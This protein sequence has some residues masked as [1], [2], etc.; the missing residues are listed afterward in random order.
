MKKTVYDILIIS[1]RPPTHSAGLGNASI[2]AL[3]AAGHHVD[4]MT[5]FDYPD[6]ENNII[7][8]LPEISQIKPSKVR[9]YVILPIRKVLLY[10]NI[11]TLVKRIKDRI[12]KRCSNRINTK[13]LMFLYPDES[14]PPIPPAIIV[15]NI[16]KKYDAV[17][18]GFW[19]GLLNTTSLAAIYEH[20]HCPIIIP[21]PDMAPITGG[22]YY[23][24]ECRNFHNGCG[25]CPLL[26]SS[27]TCDQ[28]RKNFE[29]K[30]QN[31]SKINCAFL[32][33]TWMRKHAEESKLFSNIFHLEV[34]IDPNVF[35]PSDMNVARTELGLGNNDRFM[36]LI[37][38][39]FQ[40]RKGIKDIVYAIERFINNTLP[41]VNQAVEFIVIGDDYFT[42][43]TKNLKIKTHYLGTV[44]TSQLVN[45]YRA[46]NLFISASND[47]AGPS[48]I[49][50]SLM[51]GTPVVCYDNGTALDVIVNNVSGH[52]SA[53]GD[54]DG[55]AQGIVE[56]LSQSSEKYNEMRKASHDMAMRHNSPEV[57]VR[58]RIAAIETLKKLE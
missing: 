32:G 35:S 48:M 46:A 34:M 24:G 16:K 7:T 25:K 57:C 15:Q 19:E 52:K 26:K 42:S 44:K 11:Y 36:I 49:N 3:E 37:A 17:I 14:N 21:S 38:S 30:R 6:K 56:I 10:T 43:L 29:L 53:P 20:L 18:T 27:E 28:S 40:P 54:K 23:F 51:C 39:S 55:L 58:S 41:Y 22:C 9:K 31:Y 45:C 50:Q 5:T 13:N 12:A 33:N 4:Y 1:S 47:D 8:L 2:R